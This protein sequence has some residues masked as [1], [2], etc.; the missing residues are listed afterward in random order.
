MFELIHAYLWS[1]SILVITTKW[2]N[3][4]GIA[5]TECPT[6]S[7]ELTSICN[8]KKKKNV[9]LKPHNDFLKGTVKH[10]VT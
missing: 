1:I 10:S 3:L 2:S 6:V 9:F 5:T 8:K 4:R 7:V